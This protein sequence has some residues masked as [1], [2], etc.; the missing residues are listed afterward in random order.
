MK[1]KRN[2][3]LLA[4]LSKSP[5]RAEGIASTQTTRLG[6]VVSWLDNTSVSCGLV[7]KSLRDCDSGIYHCIWVESEHDH[8]IA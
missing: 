5:S 8:L 6:G 3:R 1:L 4:R 2:L 7:A